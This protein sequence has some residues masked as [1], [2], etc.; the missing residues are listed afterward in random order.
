MCDKAVYDFVTALKFIPDWFVT[1]KII[2]KLHNALFT[3]DD[4]LFFV[5]DC[6]NANFFGDEMGI[7]S[8]DLNNINLDDINFYGDN[9]E[10]I[11]HVRLMAWR[12]R[13]KQCKAFKKDISK[14]LIPLAWNSN[15]WW[16]WCMS[17]DEKKVVEPSFTD[18][19]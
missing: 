2:K 17:E 16:D 11:I 13:L 15:R 5:E 12:N 6:N 8:V 10:T 1:G 9:P 14:E 18:K 19:N 4:I 7:L 3:H